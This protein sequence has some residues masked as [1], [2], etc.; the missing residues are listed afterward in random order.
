[1]RTS[2]TDL[3]SLHRALEEENFV[4]ELRCLAYVFEGDIRNIPQQMKIQSAN[5]WQECVRNRAFSLKNLSA[6]QIYSKILS[7]P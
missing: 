1:M 3:I 5:Y 6:T 4:H 2:I 7:R